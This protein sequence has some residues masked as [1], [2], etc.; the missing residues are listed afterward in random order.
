MSVIIITYFTIEFILTHI[1]DVVQ[2]L[3]QESSFIPTQQV[4]AETEYYLQKTDTTWSD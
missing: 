2:V 4:L 1:F 3:L